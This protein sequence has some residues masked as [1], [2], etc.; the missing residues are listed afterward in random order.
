MIVGNFNIPLILMDH[1]NKNKSGNN[2]LNDTAEQLDIIGIQ[3]TFHP[4]QQNILLQMHTE[5]SPG[6]IKHLK[7]QNKSQQI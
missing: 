4:K 7:P 1:P 6:W 2:V 5:F 3:R